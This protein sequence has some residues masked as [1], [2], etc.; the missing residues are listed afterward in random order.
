MFS[1]PYNIF[2]KIDIAHLLRV[3]LNFFRNI[4]IALGV[5]L[6]IAIILS[7]TDYPYFAYHWLGTNNSKLSKDPNV[8]V[9][10]SGGG[11]PS[12]DGLIRSYF[13]A[14]IALDY[15][16][17]SVILA[18]PA[19]TSLHKYSPEKLTA[20]EIILRGVDST[21]IILEPNGNNTYTQAKNI[22]AM[23]SEMD[24]DSL[25]LSIVTSPEHM[26]RSI[27]TFRKV[28]F[29]NVGGRPSFEEPLSNKQLIKKNLKPN[30]LKKEMR[31]LGMRYNMWNYLK[32]EI[33]VL[34]EYSAIVYYKLHGWM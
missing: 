31:Q 12:A 18:V 16:S 26:Y 13:T 11:M 28:G 20:K 24:P 29:K 22:M 5:F 27:A 32:Y 14:E 8:I 21:R 30:E 10:L 23:L 3:I 6:L 25:V 2:K 9:M 34:R 1:R 17:A 33:S 7:F 19:D 15:P 4:L